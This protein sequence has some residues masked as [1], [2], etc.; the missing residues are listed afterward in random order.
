[1]ARRPQASGL[2]GSASLLV[3]RTFQGLDPRLA[4]ALAA[5]YRRSSLPPPALPQD[6]HLVLVG[7]RAAGKTR[8]LPL[9]A[10]LAGRPPLD[11]D[12]EL[13]A[14]HHRSIPDWVRE[15]VSG[16]RAAERARFAAL[17]PPAVVAVGGGFLSL[18]ADLL[19]GHL[20]VLVPVSFD[21]YRERLLADTGRPRLRPELSLEEEI[22]QVYQERELAHARVPT[23]PLVQ[24]LAALHP[25][26]EE[27]G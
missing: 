13:E 23:V 22:V 9:V 7:H 21:T 8:L 12:E 18:H 19:A 5:E 25:P 10:E 26:G 11:L 15:D 16:F 17:R 1:M 24:L 6:G 3:A 4:P 20:A 14:F 27:A 2:N